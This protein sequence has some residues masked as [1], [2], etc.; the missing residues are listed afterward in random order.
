D[1]R[2]FVRRLPR[3]GPLIAAREIP[4]TFDFSVDE[5]TTTLPIEAR[6]AASPVAD[7]EWSRRVGD[8]LF[9]LD[10]AL[11]TRARQA[12]SRALAA[13]PGCLAPADEA[14]IC[15]WLGALDL[16]A[17][18]AGSALELLARA[19]ARGDRDLTTVTNRAV[20]LEALGR[21]G[22]AADAWAEVAARAGDSALGAR[23]R[24]R[25]AHLNR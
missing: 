6:P 1:A 11:S 15:A 14:R 17:G 7:C 16:E 2:V 9:E 22:E 5:G 20:A 3:F 23:A 19:L 25:R 24:E 4:A 18:R 8:L 10:G 13:P 21:A 12:Y